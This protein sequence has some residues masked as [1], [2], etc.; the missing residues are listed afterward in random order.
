MNILYNNLILSLF[1]SLLPCPPPWLASNKSVKIRVFSV[2]TWKLLFVKHGRIG[3]PKLVEFQQFLGLKGLADNLCGGL[4]ANI[5]IRISTFHG[6][7]D[8]YVL[9]SV[10]VC[11]CCI[12]VFI[13]NILRK[14]ISQ[15][16]T[17]LKNSWV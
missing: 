17:K 15:E 7:S 1:L 8:L 6:G 10:H 5:F 16:R 13:Y 4:L 2:K 14:K 11:T 3:W 9:Q 12:A